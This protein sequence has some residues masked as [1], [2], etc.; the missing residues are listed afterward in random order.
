MLRDA[1]RRPIPR[2]ILAWFA[3]GPAANRRWAPSAHSALPG[4]SKRRST[5]P[6]RG[7][8]PSRGRSPT[9]PMHSVLW[10]NPIR[11]VQAPWLP[12]SDARSARTLSFPFAAES[13]SSARVPLTAL[14]AARRTD[15]TGQ[16][17]GERL[18]ILR[19]TAQA[20]RDPRERCEA[21]LPPCS[22]RGSAGVERAKRRYSP[23][24]TADPRTRP[25]AA[26]P[27]RFSSTAHTKPSLPKVRYGPE[28]PTDA[29]ASTL[30]S[31]R[32]DPVPGTPDHEHHIAQNPKKVDCCRH[33][34]NPDADRI[35]C[36]RTRDDHDPGKQQRSR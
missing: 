34:E 25:S 11:R 1:G 6:P 3:T 26:P 30:R 28:F 31:L 2:S 33:C 8:L 16:S 21:A 22:R 7:R 36:C 13:T 14:T 18:P 9:P 24:S 20:R 12:R 4:H 5:S 32:R 35:T 27:D 29:D 10:A 23:Q 17:R 19:A 15:R